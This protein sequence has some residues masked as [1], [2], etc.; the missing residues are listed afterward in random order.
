MIIYHSR[1]LIH[2]FLSYQMLEY[3]YDFTLDSHEKMKRI[4]KGIQGEEQAERWLTEF[5]ADCDCFYVNDL[6]LNVDY[7]QVQIDS[8]IVFHN[9]VIVLEVKNY[10]MDIRCQNGQFYS[11]A[12][13]PLTGLNNQ[14]S[15]LARLITKALQSYDMH[16]EVKVMPFFV[17]VNQS[18]H[19]VLVDGPVLTPVNFRHVL[20]KFVDKKPGNQAIADYLISLNQENDFNRKFEIDYSHVAKGIYCPKC[21]LKI[22]KKSQR[23]YYCETCDKHFSTQCI[24]NHQI[25]VFRHLFSDRQLTTR[26]LHEWVAGEISH[27]TLQ[28]ILAEHYVYEKESRSYSK[29]E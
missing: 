8:A 15:K 27:R 17:D 6:R 1:T 21:H 2:Q 26:V 28:R 5:F 19:G 24:V 29:R 14:L 7:E 9:S 18:V 20:R 3:R 25:D 10:S 12:G 23:N 13:E 16:I 4:G 11:I 22:I